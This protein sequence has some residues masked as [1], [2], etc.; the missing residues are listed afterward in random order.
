MAGTCLLLWTN[1]IKNRRRKILY[2]KLDK[3]RDALEKARARR[4]AAEEK[5]QRLEEK[6]KEEENLQIINNVSS[7]H[8]SPEQLAQFLQLVKTRKIPELMKGE[9]AMPDMDN[10]DQVKDDQEENSYDKE[11]EEDVL[12]EN[13]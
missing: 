7:Y 1:P 3:L 6:L 10:T 9:I 5:V 8:L 12:N 2:A 4:D 13:E 11:N